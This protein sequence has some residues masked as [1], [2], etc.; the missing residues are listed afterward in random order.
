MQISKIYIYLFLYAL[1]INT[2]VVGQNGSIRGF[3][4]EKE[5]G[6]PII[7]CNV[8]LSGTSYGAATDVNGFFNITKVKPGNYT[9][10]I[11]F[12]GYDTKKIPVTITANKIQSKKIFLET[13]SVM[14]NAVDV[15]GEKQEMQTQVKMS[16]VK[17]TPKQIKQIPTIGSEPDL[18]QYLQVLPGVIF[19]GDQ[20]GQLYIRGGS[21]IQNKVLLDGMVVYNPFHSIGLFSVFDSDIIRNVDVYT[22]GFSAQ[23]GDRISS[24][25]DITMRDGNK[26][27]YGGKVSISPFGAKLMLEGPIKRAISQGAGSSS[28]IFSTKHS[29]L[30]KSSKIFY[31]YIDTAG[32]PFNYTDFYGKISLNSSNGS[33]FNIF[34]FNFNDQVTYQALSNLHWHESGLG[35]NFILVPVSSSALIK[36]GLSFSNYAISLQDI[37][38]KPRES[39]ING[40]NFN[41]S[42]NYFLGK[43]EFKYGFELSGFKTDLTFYN[44]VGRKLSQEENTTELGI[45]FKYKWALG[46]IILDPSF[47]LQYYVS[48]SEMSPEP[49]LGAKYNVTDNFRLKFATG[50][51]TQNF[52]SASSDRDVVNLFY[53][54][55]SGPENLQDYFDGKEV[56][57]KLQKSYH[58]IF[59]FEYNITRQWMLNIEGYYKYFPQLTNINRNKIYDDTPENA[60]K[61]D[62]YKKDFIIEKGNAYGVDFLL[63]YDYKRLYIWMVYSLGYSNRNDGYQEYPTH[64][65]R[66]HNVN[67]VMSYQFGKDLN[68]EA[69]TRWNLG[70]GFPFTQT[71]GEY[72]EIGFSEIGTNY[73]SANG[74]VGFVYGTINDARL[75]VYHRLDATLKHWIDFTNT[76]RLEFSLSITNIYNRNNVFYFD[77]VQHKRVDQLPFMPS[78]GISFKF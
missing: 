12:I 35:T 14:L 9:L 8:M 48:L 28:F 47:R 4:Y 73:T 5:T 62:Y 43:D 49:R 37:D 74:Q 38:A 19:T 29:Y 16:I 51:Y 60:D 3:V 75:P 44:S 77:R 33:K 31:N 63:K 6:E 39:D 32:L 70:S 22:G 66:R 15:S 11:S 27:H 61:P 36:A 10:E 30:E 68:W 24:I 58:G 56:K 40:F 67:L 41:M 59:G 72:E 18:A 7:F 78:I 76:N 52:I 21:P 65:D 13:S 50:Y 2:L 45:F 57:S 42:Y 34:G 53:G 71:A 55:L 20:G 25:M 54:F 69:G 1:F 17:V 26:N 46:K 64:F 23:Y